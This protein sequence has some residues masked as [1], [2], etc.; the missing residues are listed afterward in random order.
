M[1]YQELYEHGY[2]ND[3]I[4]AKVGVTKYAVTSWRNRNGLKQVVL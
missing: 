3:E 2:E 4:A 1:R